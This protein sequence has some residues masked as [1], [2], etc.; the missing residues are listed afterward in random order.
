M[1]LQHVIFDLDGTL[2]DSSASILA[3]FAQAFQHLGVT[4]VRALSPEVIGPPLM[5]TLAALAGSDDEGLLRGLAQQFKAHYDSEGYRQAEVFAG[6]EA[7]LESL[8]G[9]F[10]LY[11]ATN[12]RLLPTQRIMQHLGWQRLFVGVYALDYFTPA[13]PHKLAMVTRVLARHAIAAEHAIYIGDRLEDGQAAEGNALAFAMVRWGY[14]D[15]S[16]G[17][18][19]S[20]WR[21]FD[22]PAALGGHLL[23]LA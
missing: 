17:Q 3:S 19:P 9:R 1:S 5:Q 23:S 8:A 11:I 22:N 20:H 14:L 18:I 2:I 13:A 21:Q 4:P 7:M 6:V 12:K 16:L 15:D 10:P